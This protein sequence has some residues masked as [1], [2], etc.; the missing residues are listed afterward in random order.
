MSLCPDSTG[1]YLWS[2][3]T[4]K[5]IFIH[6]W[7]T[8]TCELA[9]ELSHGHK[10]KVNSFCVVGE[11]I[12]SSGDD[13]IICVW[14][15]KTFDLLQQLKGHQGA[16]YGLISFGDYVWS[17]G[18]DTAIRVWDTLSFETVSELTD[19]HSDCISSVQPIRKLSKTFAW[20]GSW[21]KSICVFQVNEKRSEEERKRIDALLTNRNA[22]GRND[23]DHKLEDTEKK[24]EELRRRNQELN[25]R[26]RELQRKKS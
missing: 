24:M 9:R 4:D 19:Y 22:S 21:D 14:D 2:G 18:W 25:I 17:C 12:W 5:S 1:K 26:N 16:I 15:T 13:N 6:V 20:T 10:K 7:N 11:R 8:Q 3:T 23:E